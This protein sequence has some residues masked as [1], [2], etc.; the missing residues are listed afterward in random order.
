MHEVAV[1][2][3]VI[4]AALAEL[5]KHD[6]S[7]VKEMVLVVG[8]LTSLGEEQ[9]TFAYDIMIKNTSLEGSRLVIEREEVVLLCSSCG[10][11][12]PAETLESDYH[13]H[14]VP[15]LSCPKCKGSVKVTAGDA[16]RISSLKIVGE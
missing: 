2:S 12:G 7:A 3:S 11:D 8:D 14:T 6:V 15:I 10:Y 1:M 13:E 4:Q 9:L 5:E 16:C